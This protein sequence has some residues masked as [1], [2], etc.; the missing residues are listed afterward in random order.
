MN[1]NYA[2]N[3]KG[4][5]EYF[6]FGKFKFPIGKKT[7]VM[8]ILNITPDS[9]SD[10]GRYNDLFSALKKAGEMVNEGADIIDVGG[11]ST[12]PGHKEISTDEE[13]ERVIPVIERL[14]KEI[15]V[16]VSIDTSKAEVAQ[17][18]L[19]AGASIVN[20]V[21]GLQKDPELAGVISE[22]NAGIIMMHNQSHKNY[23]E[24]MGDIIYFLMKS[25]EIAEKAGVARERMAL[26]PGIGFGKTL[27]QNLEVMKRLN[28]L[29]R[30][31]FAHP[32][33]YLKKVIYWK[34]SKPAC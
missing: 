21:W 26:D 30:F 27:E 15:D 18:A 24:L 6:E 4:K 7:Y 16:P 22:Y 10:G 19:L 8:G 34:Y 13:I 14:V 2:I 31:E 29:E 32:F 5:P 9:F 23:N 17:K 25:I 1:L 12:R 28:E 3:K 11:E 33:R 20:D